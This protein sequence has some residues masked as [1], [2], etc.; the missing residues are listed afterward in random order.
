VGDYEMMLTLSKGEVE[1][2]LRNAVEFLEVT[3]GLLT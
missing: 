1:E 3:K 2:H